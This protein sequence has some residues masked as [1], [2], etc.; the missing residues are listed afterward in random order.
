MSVLPPYHPTES[1]SD[2]G[3]TTDPPFINGKG[4]NTHSVNFKIEALDLL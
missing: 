4:K 1:S 3:N 2:T